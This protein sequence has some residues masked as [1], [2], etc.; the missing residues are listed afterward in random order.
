MHAP[1][2][3]SALAASILAT[4]APMAMAAQ[5][6]EIVVT[7]TKRTESLQDVPISVNAVSG[8]KMDQA[9]IT[10]LEKMTAYVP[11]FSMNQTGIS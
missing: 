9:G 4:L 3:R 5:L 6:E 10:N 2:R 7:A 8:M 1:F 11:N